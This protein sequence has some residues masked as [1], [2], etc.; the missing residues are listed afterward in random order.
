[1]S[2][3]RHLHGVSDHNGGMEVRVDVLGPLRLIVDGDEIA[4]P[5]PKR[6]AVLALLATAESHV[7]S[8]DDLL[9]ALWP[10]DLPD[11]AKATLQSHVSRLRRHLGGAAN[12]IE[13]VGAGYRLV[14]GPDECDLTN[15]DELYRAAGEL[16]A[17]R[18]CRMLDA[19]RALWRGKALAEFAD[20]APLQARAVTAAELRA[21]IEEA[22]IDSLLALGDTEH[23]VVAATEHAATEPLSE[24]AVVLLMRALHAADRTADALRA[25]YDFRRRLAA[26]TGLHPTTTLSDL[27]AEL[28]TA[29]APMA[30]HIS[31]SPHR[32]RGR[33]SDLAA[34]RRLLASERL[35]TLVGPGGVGKTRLAIEVAA[36]WEP[37]TAVLLA[38]VTDEHTLPQ[39]IADALGLRVI[40]GDITSACAALLAAGP[41][42]LLIDNCEHQLGAVC[43]VVG[44][45]LETCPQLTIL[46]TSREPL[47]LPAEQRLRLAPLAVSQPSDLE[48]IARSPA[49]AVF[50]D[51]ATKVQP[52]LGLG[53]VGLATIT[54]IVRRLDGMPLAIQLAAA[55]LS[56][57]AIED[58]HAHIDQ[59]LDLLGD[60]RDGTL[61]QT[62]AWSYDLLPDDE[63]RLLRYLSVFADGLDLAAAEATAVDL[64]VPEP[65]TAL[66]HLVDASM[67][68]LTPGTIGRYR[69]LDTVRAFATD[70]LTER[71]EA[72]TATEQFLGWALGLA[73]WIGDATYTHDERRVDIAIRR[74]LPNLRAAWTLLRA[75]GRTDDAI[76]MVTG[77]L[78]AATWRD[79][80]DVWEWSLELAADPQIKSHTCGPT[81]L[82][83]AA[84][85]AW[86]RGDLDRAD[87]LANTGIELA[88]TDEWS[89]ID[90]KSLVALSRGDLD[91]AIEHATTAGQTATRPAQS[92]GIA[93]LASAYRG[94][95]DRATALNE[96]FRA[97]AV[98][99]TLEAFHAYIGGEIAGLEAE[100][101]RALAHYDHAIDLARSV[102][103]TFVDGVASVGRLTQ[104]AKSGDTHQ[105]LGGYRVLIDYWERTGSWIQQWTTLRNVADLLHQEGELDAATF[106]R[107][108]AASAPDAPPLP[109]NENH[110]SPAADEHLSQLVAEATRASRSHVLAIARDAIDRRLAAPN[111]QH[112]PAGRRR[113][114]DG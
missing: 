19:A 81:I 85:S 23:A 44:R 73:A 38:A 4:V 100:P 7:L 8:T 80:T 34:L 107:A 56:S 101:N 32:L 61:R 47:G 54:E 88:G 21:R 65:L 79:L 68:E 82:G 86:F 64:D 67:L 10:E 93:A 52:D 45:F 76:A 87:A 60:R 37:A 22:Y 15:A 55:R 77:L 36:G 57:L 35:V 24:P 70:E 6:R 16:D 33:D 102:G 42:L 103:S 75:G 49:V 91:A 39:A 59:A 1:M 20:V 3:A 94:D 112:R 63:Q 11:T 12:R 2:L 30:G 95:I 111:P 18:A 69:M 53:A 99:P 58:L 41:R 5:G 26:E 40:H 50:I 71:G 98:S 14:L 84:N 110:A 51:H 28:A 96:T 31:R 90:A 113:D 92:F 13:G 72:E 17:A 48:S 105:A 104:I 74:E 29:A 43:Q 108:A 25:A 114:E 97:V 46:A 78:D 27:E 9:D 106:M 109:D 89:C 62:I 66:G 83:F